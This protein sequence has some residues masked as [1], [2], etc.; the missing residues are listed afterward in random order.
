MVVGS[1]W[2]TIL[3]VLTDG[4]APIE[5]ILGTLT[6]GDLSLREG[7]AIHRVVGTGLLIGVFG[8]L[9]ECTRF[10]VWLKADEVVIGACK[11]DP[12]DLLWVIALRV[13]ADHLVQV[14]AHWS[15]SGVWLDI[16]G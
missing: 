15:L 1:H 4:I 8:L 3:D 11:V 9:D 5:S 16:R 13:E 7:I 12:G 6:F 14:C 10:L 2:S